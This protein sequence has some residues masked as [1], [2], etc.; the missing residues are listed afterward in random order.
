MPITY[1]KDWLKQELLDLW[2]ANLMYRDAHIARIMDY[3]KNEIRR[4]IEQH[5]AEQQSQ[6]ANTEARPV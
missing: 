3:I 4:G 1:R 6:E 2:G 5:R